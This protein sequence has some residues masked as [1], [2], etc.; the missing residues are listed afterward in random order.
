MNIFQYRLKLKGYTPITVREL[1]AIIDDEE[2]I[3][4]GSSQGIDCSELLS[5][6][7]HDGEYRCDTTGIGLVKITKHQNSQNDAYSIEYSDECGDP[8]FEV[9]GYDTPIDNEGDGTWNYGL[10]RKL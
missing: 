5:V 10:Y 6:C 3:G 1:Q 7:W 4:D 2:G 8:R 9:F